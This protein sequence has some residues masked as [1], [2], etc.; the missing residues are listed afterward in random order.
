MLSLK[1]LEQTINS[2]LYMNKT[3][4]QLDKLVDVLICAER[5]VDDDM[6]VF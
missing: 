6:I 2:M 3:S 4:T 5:N 1:V